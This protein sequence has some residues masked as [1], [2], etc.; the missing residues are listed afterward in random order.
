MG[1]FDET[2]IIFDGACGTNLQGLPL[3]PSAWGKY[4][5]CNEYLNLSA[6]EAIE[7]LH[8]SFLSAGAMVLET[9]TFGANSVVLAEYGGC[10]QTSNI[11]ASIYCPFPVRRL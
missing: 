4:E 6:P 7:E 11:L 3:G 10:T 1:L 8:S 2:V 5:G 9:N